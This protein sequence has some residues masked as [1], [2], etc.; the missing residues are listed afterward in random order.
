MAWLSTI[1]ESLP[2]AL[3]FGGL[4][5]WIVGTNPGV[6]ARV[7]G[8]A[9][10]GLLAAIVL[11]RVF[12]RFGLPSWVFS[13]VLNRGGRRHLVGD[14]DG[15]LQLLAKHRFLSSRLAWSNSPSAG[16]PHVQTSLICPPNQHINH[17][18][19]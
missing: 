10:I 6:G 11:G 9:L 5:F 8:V 1:V 17:A 13:V 7:V 19:V 4:L 12:D 18:I 14:V 3:I 2:K 15:R 16:R